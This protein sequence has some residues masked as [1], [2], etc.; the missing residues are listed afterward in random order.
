MFR[1]CVTDAL[2]IKV[3][4]F[5]KLAGLVFF[6]PILLGIVTLSPFL[7]FFSD[8]LSAQS[9]G[10]SRTVGFDSQA[11]LYAVLCI[12]A[13]S[14]AFFVNH[15]R[16]VKSINP[17]AEIGDLRAYA[18]AER[19]ALWLI[20][21]LAILGLGVT[22]F[23]VR[24]GRADYIDVV[25]DRLVTGQSAADLYYSS[26]GYMRSE[27]VSGKIRIFGWMT[28]AAAISWLAFAVSPWFKSRKK[29]Y[30]S[31]LTIFVG[32]N[33]FRAILGGDR[34][35]AIIVFI[36]VVFDLWFRN[37][38]KNEP[39]VQKKRKD[40]AVSRRAQKILAF[41]IVLAS[42][43]GAFYL[44][45]NLRTT[46][47]GS[48]KFNT[49]LMYADLGVANLSV[50]FKTAEGMGYGTAVFLLPLKQIMAAFGFELTAW[51]Q[52]T[53]DYILGNPANL[54]TY[55]YMDFGFFGFI[56]YM[57]LGFF[58][59]WIMRQ[60]R[61]YPASLTW[62][63]ASL[64]LLFA[65]AGVFTV[66][67]F[68]SAGYWLSFGASILLLAYVERYVRMKTLHFNKH[69]LLR[70]NGHVINLDHNEER[71]TAGRTWI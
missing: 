16:Q 28:N 34:H 52:Y 2:E 64:Y 26:D 4:M 43:L 38:S 13:F 66:P 41:V 45:S 71:H 9:L 40:N 18:H 22:M 35:P 15:V 47:H 3:I 68:L 23:S 25:L 56:D 51:P 21:A 48:Q 36:L 19:I 24:A 6:P 67:I 65:L 17:H 11:L 46:Q 33:L 1:T 10:L 39:E 44:L 62:R 14:F 37:G 20:F 5:Q 27:F 60:V 54:L 53:R 12:L 8:T 50:A 57:L 61:A 7:I 55:A 59:G 49:I 30:Y 58:S 29:F 63:A 42:G 69:Q 31:V 32:I 70:A